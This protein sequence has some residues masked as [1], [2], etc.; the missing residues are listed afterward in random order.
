MVNV[1]CVCSVG[2]GSSLM[3]KMNAEKIL[4][5]HGF[6]VRAENTN[7]TSASGMSADLL[8]TTPDVYD[9]IRNCTAKQTILMDN[10]V[11]KKEL[12][13]KITAIE[14]KL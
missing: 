7:V 9:Q 12:E 1:L 14:D 5:A 6:K 10:M 11:S 3:L 8:I 2:V 13:E 4:K